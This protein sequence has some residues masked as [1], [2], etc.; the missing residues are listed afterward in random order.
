MLIESIWKTI[1]HARREEWAERQIKAGQ[2]ARN[3]GFTCVE[4]VRQGRRPVSRLMC[5]VKA[6]HYKLSSA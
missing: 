3:I 4:S 1:S 6:G 2:E 5:A